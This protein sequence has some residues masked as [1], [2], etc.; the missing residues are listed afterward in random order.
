ME[1]PDDCR[2]PLSASPADVNNRTSKNSSRGQRCDAP[3]TS[4]FLLPRRAVG[5]CPVCVTVAAWVV[6]GHIYQCRNI[7]RPLAEA[8]SL[9]PSDFDDVCLSRPLP[10]H[11]ASTVCIFPAFLPVFCTSASLS[12]VVSQSLSE[13]PSFWHFLLTLSAPTPPTPHTRTVIFLFGTL[14]C[15][16]I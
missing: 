3:R 9:K 15:W 12:K 1:A 6:M 7:S 10:T 4:N 11:S 8:F 2:H 16:I 13:V 14:L 5:V